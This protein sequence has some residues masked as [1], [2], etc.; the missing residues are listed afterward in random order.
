MS[1]VS[2]S[3]DSVTERGLQ[4]RE[5]IYWMNPVYHAPNFKT[6]SVGLKIELEK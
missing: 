1:G 5:E 6:I 4:Y 2:E 3:Y